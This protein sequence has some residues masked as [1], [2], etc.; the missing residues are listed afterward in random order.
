MKKIKNFF[1]TLKVKFVNL[2]KRKEK[3][4]KK[5]EPKLKFKESKM[6]KVFVSTKLSLKK[7]S[8]FIVPIAVAIAGITIGIL[9]RPKEG[10]KVNVTLV[11]DTTTHRVFLLSDDNMVVPVSV[12]LEERMTKDEEILDVFNLIKDNKKYENDTMRGY[13]PSDTKLNDIKLNNGI[14]TLDFSS[15]FEKL[16]MKNI[17]RTVEALTYTFL[18]FDGVNGLRFCVDGCL[19]DKV[20]GNYVIPTVLDKS[21]GI[22]KQVS[23]LSET[24]KSEEV[25]MIY[26]K[27]INKNNFYVPMT[28]EAEKGQTKVDTVYNAIDIKPSTYTGLK[29]VKEYSYLNMS[30]SPVI[31]D[32]TVSLDI[33]KEGMVDDVTISKELY[34]L[35]ALT[36]DYSDL[37]YRVN[38]TFEGEDY[39]VD[40]IIDE[41]DFKVSSFVYNEVQL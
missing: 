40:G 14:L 41:E 13:I 22:N 19:T 4:V 2:F 33:T 5:K 24:S 39:E 12:S 21:I 7:A 16:P 9:T 27:K 20:A 28:V 8:L 30:S 11:D 36:F 31:N 26:N 25:V 18:D 23:S 29:K 15:E 34:E 10:V 6:P 37:D 3:I 1:L 35:M 38:L 32:K 17:M